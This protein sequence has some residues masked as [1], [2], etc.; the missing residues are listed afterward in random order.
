MRMRVGRG[1]IYVLG[2]MTAA[3]CR[4][5]NVYCQENPAA[6]Q[7]EASALLN[8]MKKRDMEQELKSL[9]Q[10]S[11]NPKEV[12]LSES[13]LRIA[14]DEVIKG[15]G[16]ITDKEER[17]AIGAL[18]DSYTRNPHRSEHTV[19]KL[20]HKDFIQQS[21]VISRSPLSVLNKAMDSGCKATGS[22]AAPEE[23]KFEEYFVGVEDRRIKE[24]RRTCEEDEDRLF[25][26][27]RSL[28]AGGCAS[29][30]PCAF[31]RNE[32]GL[33]T[34]ESNEQFM[35][36]SNG[37]SW[38]YNGDILSFGENRP[39]VYGDPNH[40]SQ[41][42]ITKSFTAKFYIKDKPNVSEF[43]VISIH[44]NNLLRISI[45]GQLIR[46]GVAIG[47]GN[48]W[49]NAGKTVWENWEYDLKPLLVEGWNELQLELLYTMGGHAAI[50]I[51]ARQYCCNQWEDDKWE[52]DCPVD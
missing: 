28:K 36:A 12:T 16:T 9:P 18:R 39:Y 15:G 52:G 20:Q 47:G 30:I 49:H 33:Y 27:T 29:K 5:D 38:E 26:C 41:A 14:G 31:N 37:L 35:R 13:D 50:R 40:G 48:C 42:C 4:A 34:S 8:E 44:E 22:E 32:G 21:D 51:R 46:D 3:L 19:G 25:Y 7:P 43:R 2:I 24:T 11:E 1:L 6:Y 23:A 10:F 17:E 45:N